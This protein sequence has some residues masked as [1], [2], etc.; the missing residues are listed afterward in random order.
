VECDRAI[1]VNGIWTMSPELSSVWKVASVGDSRQPRSDDGSD[2]LKGFKVCNENGDI[3]TGDLLCTSSTPG[4]L[5]K[6]GDDI[7]KSYTVGKSMEDV[8][9]D[10]EGKAVD[11]YGY[12]YCG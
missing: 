6:Q 5:M 12:I 4:Y 10:G 2:Y 11:I 8:V 9:F 3:V 7:I 1:L